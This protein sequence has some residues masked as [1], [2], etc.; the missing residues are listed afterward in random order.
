MCLNDVLLK[1]PD[2]LTSLLG[3]L[4]RFRRFPVPIVADIEKMYHQVLVPKEDQSAL[5]FLYR[6]PG[7]EEVETFQMTRHV[8]GA[9]SSPSVC[10]YALR[11][12]AEDMKESFPEVARLAVSNM[13]VDNLLY[14]VETEE[15]AIR[16]AQQFKQLCSHGGFNLV[17]WMSSSRQF[18]SSVSPSDLSKPYFDFQS[19]LLPTER[20]LGVALEWESDCF[21]FDIELKE[22]TTMREVLRELSRI[23]DPLGLICPLVLPGRILMQEVWRSKVDWDDPLPK[24]IRE[25]WSRWRVEMQ[26]VKKIR[27]PRCVQAKEVPTDYQIHAFSDASGSGYGAGI[28]LRTTYAS[29]RVKINLV[30]GKARV[31][32]LKQLS[33]PRLELLGAVTAVKLAAIVR[34]EWN[35]PEMPVVYWTDSQTVLQWIWSTSCKYHAFVAHRITE[36]LDESTPMQWRH[37]PGELNPADDASRGISAASLTKDHRWFYGPSFL[38]LERVN[39]PEML[40]PTEPPENDVEVCRAR[41][42]GT[43]SI[44]NPHLIYD[45]GLRVSSLSLLKNVVGWL[46][47]FVRN[48]PHAGAPK[49]GLRFLEAAELREATLFIV[50]VNQHHHF[51]RELEAIQRNSHLPCSSPLIHLTPFIDHQGVLR[52]RGRLHRGAFSEDLKNPIILHP[53]S[54]FATLLVADVHKN[55]CHA[56]VIDTLCAIRASYFILQARSLVK[57]IVNACIDCRKRKAQPGNQLM[58]PLPPHR[59]G[60]HSPPF[61]YNVIDYF[62]PISFVIGRKTVLRYGVLFTC[63]T[64]RAVHLEIAASLD[65]ES[66]LFCVLEIR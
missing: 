3:V 2:F 35:C 49:K 38:V 41:W 61:T 55:L 34:K 9:V 56:S 18:L 25:V 58:A 28:Y 24:N 65:V 37:I 29:G 44:K 31:A 36:I 27:I 60:V 22:A 64:I 17:Q 54:G 32:P 66:F 47:R 16:Q 50:R 1:G 6:K 14:S 59:L 11:R 15:K 5:R 43:M 46:L 30:I 51:F 40:Q 42:C 7:S 13:Y 57:Q 62:G 23:H 20:T 19:K 53:K 8:F 39:W 63:L 4:L 10:I 45:F 12:T 21:M 33:I 52:V 48:Y 26:A